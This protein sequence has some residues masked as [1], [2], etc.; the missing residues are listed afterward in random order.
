MVR[1]AS[2]TFKVPTAR[3]FAIIKNESDGNPNAFNPETDII[4][5]ES[6]GLMGIKYTS[7]VQ[8][9]YTGKPEGL[10]DPATNITFGTKYLKWIQDNYFQ[11]SARIFSAYNQG[12]GNV[13]KFG[14]FGSP[15]WTEKVR[16]YVLR[17]LQ[18]EFFIG[19]V[20]D[21]NTMLPMFLPVGFLAVIAEIN[22]KV[23]EAGRIK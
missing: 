19:L 17:A 10:K 21:L 15:K 22:E 13:Q 18:T 4:G 16:A 1:S 11:D 7:A 5:D 8:V 23:R 3:I 12:V 20:E 6:Y 2:N 9:G 14:V